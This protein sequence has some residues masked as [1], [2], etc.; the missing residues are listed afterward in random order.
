LFSLR[1]SARL[2]L[3]E[4][5][6]FVSP[7]ISAIVRPTPS[8]SVRVSRANGVYLPTP[9]TDE[10]EASGLRY[11]DMRRVGLEHAKEW[12]VD[13]DGTRGALD[14][15]ASGYRTVVTNPLA[16]RIEPGSAIGLQIVNAEEPSRV[17]G[18]DLSARWRAG[19]MRV[20]AAYSYVD[21]ERPMIGT[22]TGAD[23][24]FDTTMHRAAP[25]TPPHTARVEAVHERANDRLIGAE[26]RFTGTQALADSSLA[27][28]RAFVT[29]DAR[30]E[31]HVRQAIVFL[32]GSNLLN[33]K[34]SGYAPVLRSSAGAAGQLADNVWAPLEGIVLNAGVRIL[35]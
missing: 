19:A 11:V 22:I 6:D 30:F 26:L 18:A 25:Y 15:R 20:T 29:V 5:G 9:L 2:D 23:F 17:Q 12:S 28:S 16:I 34:Q 13:V 24:E 33:V 27:P 31:K 14:L 8:W 1:S 32:R 4:F 21:A 35:Y 7:R 10:T 3:T